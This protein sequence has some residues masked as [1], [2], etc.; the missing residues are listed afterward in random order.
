MPIISCLLKSIKIEKYFEIEKHKRHT[1][2]WWYLLS[3]LHSWIWS[4]LLFDFA[5]Q[6]IILFNNFFFYRWLQDTFNVPLVIQLTDDEKFLFKDLTKE[7][8]KRLAIQVSKFN[9]SNVIFY[10]GEM[11]ADKWVPVFAVLNWL[12]VLWKKIKFCFKRNDL[13]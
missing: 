12:L 6:S 1:I 4:W 3:I 7:E 13:F 10:T 8:S 2:F 11:L 9:W 5:P